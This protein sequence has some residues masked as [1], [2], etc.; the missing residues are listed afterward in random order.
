MKPELSVVIPCLN[1]EK[2]IASC[3][4]SLIESSFPFHSMEIMVVDGMSTDNTRVL[5]EPYLKKYSNIALLD[6]ADKITPVALNKGILHSTADKILISGA[7]TAFSKDYISVLWKKMDALNAHVVGGV[8]L[9]L[10]GDDSAK[11]HSIARALSSGF[12]VGNSM[13]RIGVKEDR[14]ADTVPFGMYQREVF[15]KVG[16][17]NPKLIRNQDI[18]LSGRIVSAGFSIWLCPGAVCYYKARTKFMEL[19]KNNFGNG[20]WNS[21]LMI[22][23]GVFNA[24]KIRHFA[25]LI[26]VLS[27]LLMFILGLFWFPEGMIPLIILGAFYTMLVLIYSLKENSKMCKWYYL[28]FSYVVIHTSYG[29]GML[30]GFFSGKAKK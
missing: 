29:I 17:Y 7:H 22:L 11:A 26:A 21:R 20:F 24:L 9:T 18:E 12:G 16:L 10:P 3:L 30:F 14:R 1:E 8:M 25:P 19:A 6:N 15:H 23:T 13:F 5:I 2:N 4:D 28:A 27:G